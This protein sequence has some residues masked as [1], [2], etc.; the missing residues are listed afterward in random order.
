VALPAPQQRIDI[1]LNRDQPPRFARNSSKRPK[2]PPLRQAATR[3]SKKLA[4]VLEVMRELARTEGITFED[5]SQRA[6]RKAETHGGFAERV[7][8]ETYRT[9]RSGDAHDLS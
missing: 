2:K 7:V 5:V 6:A 4:D 1:S 8:S 3:C 9:P